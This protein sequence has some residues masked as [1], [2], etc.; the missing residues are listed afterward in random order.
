MVDNR[1][2]DEV[3]LLPA[4]YIAWLFLIWVFLWDNARTRGILL[5]AHLTTLVPIPTPFRLLEVGVVV[6]LFGMTILQVRRWRTSQRVGIVLLLCLLTLS[7]ASILIS[8]LSGLTHAAPALQMVYS[9]VAP[10]FVA[11]IIALRPSRVGEATSL[12][13]GLTVAVGISAVVAWWQM[14]HLRAFGDNVHGVMR[15]AH[16]FASAIWIVVLWWIARLSARV[17][18]VGKNVLGVLFFAPTALYAANEKS[19]V[20]FALVLVAAAT[21]VLW[22]RGWFYRLAIGVLL[23][24]GAVTARAVAMG[25]I[26]LPESAGHL[27]VVMENLS[28]IGFFKGYTKVLTVT[29][30]YPRVLV[31]GTGPASY[32][33]IKAVDEVVTGG[34]PPPLAAKYTAESYRIIFAMSGLVGS[35][36]EESTDLSAFFVELGPVALL[37][38]SGAVWALVIQP[39]RRAAR[40]TDRSQIAMGRWVLLATSFVLV[41]STFTAFYGWAGVQATVWP[42]MLVVGLLEERPATSSLVRERYDPDAGESQPFS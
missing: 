36:F 22:R 26:R 5:D 14:I 18:S 24:A 21:I 13:R 15:D 40:T 9:F 8:V 3:P 17:G 7:A 10:L 12:L 31:V 42:I 2:S 37:L 27:Q 23:V 6:L 16:H 34:E 19:N 29:A 41:M 28:S 38:F 32:G 25:Q 20:A 11:V 4:R 39:A 35:Y 1:P 33:S 30:E